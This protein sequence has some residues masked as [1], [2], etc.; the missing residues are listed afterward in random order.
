M[1]KRGKQRI[2]Y[3]VVMSR[4]GFGSRQACWKIVKCWRQ[5]YT[6]NIEWVEGNIPLGS[7]KKK[8]KFDSYV[9]ICFFL[10]RIDFSS[11]NSAKDVGTSSR[12]FNCKFGGQSVYLMILVLE[13]V[14]WSTH[15]QKHFKFLAHLLS[16]LTIGENF[17]GWD[18][19]LQHNS[20]IWGGKA[21]C[22]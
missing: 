18:F 20:K 7:L 13:P 3:S 5:S 17:P 12:R 6:D 22:V 11:R 2:F 15:L 4:E 10:K 8:N 21:W 19:S 14:P 16:K 1:L 9:S